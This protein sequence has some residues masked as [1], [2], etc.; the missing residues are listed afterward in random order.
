MV[1]PK[2]VKHVLSHLLQVVFPISTH[3]FIHKQFLF[4]LSYVRNV[5]ASLQFIHSLLLPPVQLK[6]E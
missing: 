2:H 1:L 3:P 6:H 4:I 5:N